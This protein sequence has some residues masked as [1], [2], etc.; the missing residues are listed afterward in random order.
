MRFTYS[1]WITAKLEDIKSLTDRGTRIYMPKDTVIYD[2]DEGSGYVYVVEEGRV[3]LVY[4]AQDGSEHILMFALRGG[5]FGELECM[6]K[7]SSLVRA[8][9]LTDCSIYKIPE[10]GFMEA[11]SADPEITLF[12]ARELAHKLH[13]I[14]VGF[15]SISVDETK[16][17]VARILLSTAD[18]FGHK[19][20]GNI[21]I[22]LPITQQ[23]IANLV[24]STRLTVG[25]ILRD[26]M[27]LG[28]IKKQDTYFFLLD[29]AE[30]ERIAL[31]DRKD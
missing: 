10:A 21:R 19:E 2:Q 20:N 11:M 5:I 25:N 28:L 3:R 14:S 27:A 16:N 22:D 26:F 13:V 31:S 29:R 9:T 17:R 1:P 12:I 30:L 23:E 4:L 24:N 15:I 18:I 7:I 8:E 6:E